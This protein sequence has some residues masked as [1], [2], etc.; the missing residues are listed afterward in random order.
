MAQHNHILT[1]IQ[2]NIFEC[3]DLHNQP[4]NTT[5]PTYS[6]LISVRVATP[7]VIVYFFKR[8]IKN[9]LNHIDF[10]S[11]LPRRFCLFSFIFHSLRF[12]LLCRVAW[13]KKENHS[14]KS[15]SFDNAWSRCLITDQSGAFEEGAHSRALFLSSRDNLTSPRQL[16]SQWLMEVAFRVSGS[17]SDWKTSLWGNSTLQWW[18]F[19]ASMG[20][21]RFFG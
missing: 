7:P 10:N 3:V 16:T 5:K 11:H 20:A 12:I 15:K 14:L 4:D 8:R 18:E 19:V 21:V 1:L 2:P 9:L 6:H 13:F 17:L